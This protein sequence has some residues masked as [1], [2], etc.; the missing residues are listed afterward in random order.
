MH[1]IGKTDRLDSSVIN[2][3]KAEA[4][5]IVCLLRI[6]RRD[7]V[8]NYACFSISESWQLATLFLFSLTFCG[9]TKRSAELA[10]L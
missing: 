3:K 10:R 6:S 8:K 2:A 4:G 7:L 5:F 9:G 1:I